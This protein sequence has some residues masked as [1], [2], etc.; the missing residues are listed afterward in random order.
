MVRV[1]RG[2]PL[3]KLPRSG[4]GSEFRSG[5]IRWIQPTNLH[6]PGL[7][8]RVAPISQ[9][10]SIRHR[11]AR[12][13]PFRLPALRSVNQERWPCYQHGPWRQQSLKTQSPELSVSSLHTIFCTHTGTDR[14]AQSLLKGESPEEQMSHFWQDLEMNLT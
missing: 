11:E 12:A 9:S 5:S 6:P 4:T 2:V 8:Q 1:G 3:C 10:S 13:R 7:L 14:S